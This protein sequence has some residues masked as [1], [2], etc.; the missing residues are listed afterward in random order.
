MFDKLKKLSINFC[1]NIK[2]LVKFFV[3]LK[4]INLF[5]RIFI[6]WEILICNL[7]VYIDISI[8]GYVKFNFEFFIRSDIIF[9]NKFVGDVLSF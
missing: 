5:L 9:S 8:D 1:D 3:N 4:F 6:V 7:F 2:F